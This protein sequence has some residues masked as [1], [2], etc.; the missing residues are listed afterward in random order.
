R[1]IITGEF[2]NTA[3][4]IS[5]RYLFSGTYDSAGNPEG[6]EL[7]SDNSNLHVDPGFKNPY[8]DQFI[9]GFEQEIIRNVGL[10]LYYIHKRGEDYGCAH[11]TAGEYEPTAF[12]DETGRSSVVQR[13]LSDPT[14]RQ[15]QLTN[16]PE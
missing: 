3:R 12:V 11:D 7:V 1:G 14:A 9:G 8:T 16:P 4:S 15:F 5:P 2:D 6:L 10:S 13:L